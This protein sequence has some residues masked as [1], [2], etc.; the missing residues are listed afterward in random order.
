MQNS[1]NDAEG[2]QTILTRLKEVGSAKKTL[3]GMEAT[4]HYGFSLHDFLVANGYE[5]AVLHPIQTAQQAKKAIRK[6]KTDK[7]DAGHIA[8]LIKNGEHRPALVAGELPMTCRQ[9]TRLRYAITRQ[10]TRI[11]QLLWARLHPVWPE[12]ESLFATPFCATGRKL[13]TMAPPPSTT[14]PTVGTPQGGLITPPTV[15]LTHAVP[16]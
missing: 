15:L 5:V 11:K 9:V 4:G 6:A 16:P 12:Y 3:V 14:G 10:R 8:T 2:Y 7:I 1:S 13:L